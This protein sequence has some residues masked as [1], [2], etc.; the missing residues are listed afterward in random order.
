MI[1]HKNPL[2]AW[3]FMQ[4]NPEAIL[5]DVRTQVEFSFVGHPINAI[6]IPWKEAPEWQVNPHFIATA[7]QHINNTATPVLLLCRSGARSLAAAN[8]LLDHG[9]PNLIN[10]NEGFEGDLDAQKHRGNLSGWRYHN[11]P[12]EQT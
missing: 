5:I 10:I 1:V 2:E 12:W 9:H 6:H 4:S 3:D 8:A 7:Q 11:L